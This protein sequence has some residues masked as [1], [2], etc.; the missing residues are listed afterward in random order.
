MNWRF[1]LHLKGV[2]EMTIDLS[3]RLYESGCADSNPS[4]SRGRAKVSF[5]REAATLNDAIRSAVHDVRKAGVD[6][7]HV[8]IESEDLAEAELSQWAT[9]GQ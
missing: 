5:D 8:E 6:V 9:V 7:D 4:S 2:D 3:N 1:T